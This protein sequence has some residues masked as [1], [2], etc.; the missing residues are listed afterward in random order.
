VLR[1][2]AIVLIVG[3]HTDVWMV[4]GGAHTL[5]A[6]AGFGLVRFQLAGLDAATRSRRVVRMAGGIVGPAVVVAGTVAVLRGT[7]DAATVLGLNNLLGADVWTEQ[8]RLWFVEAIGWGLLLVAV[9]IRI[10]PVHRLERRA[11]YLL[12]LGLVA[13]SLVVR[14]AWIGWEA[15]NP[16]RY[17]LPFVWTF[18]LLG[19]LAAR[20]VTGRLKVATLLVA[21]LSTVGFFGDPLRESVVLGAVAVMLWL[22]QLRLPRRVVPVVGVVGASSL[23][24]YLVHWEVYPPVEE[25]SEP[26]GFAVSFACGVAAWWAWTRGGRL[27]RRARHRAG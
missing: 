15:G 22:P 2:V 6:L 24:V 13:L 16:Q 23:W 26:L 1:A 10:P 14:W 5:L 20:S 25:V 7:Y 4:P 18:L 21:A 12:P 9:A 11:P 8:W 19:W 17:S 3:S 27:L